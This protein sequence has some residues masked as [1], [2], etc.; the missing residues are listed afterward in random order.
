MTGR[1]PPPPASFLM[2]PA[3]LFCAPATLVSF[4]SSISQPLTYFRALRK[5]FF[6]HTQPQLTSLHMPTQMSHP[7]E[8][9]AVTSRTN[10]ATL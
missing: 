5:V 7:P 6:L 1:R 9:P 3:L 4:G 8:S 2:T 10:Q